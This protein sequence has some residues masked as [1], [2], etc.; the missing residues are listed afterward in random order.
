M[1]KGKLSVHTENILP[2]I[3]KWLYS[4][5]EIFLRE[6]VSNALD[7]INKVKKVALTEEIRDA[8]D[9]EYAIDIRIDRE[10][11]ELVIEDNGIGL[12]AEEIKKYIAQI[13]FS[14]A[15]EFVKQYEDSGDKNKAG[16]I[17]NFGLGFYSSFMVASRVEI[18]SLSYRPNAQAARW[19]SDGGEEYEIGEGTRTKRG[20][21]IKLILEDEDKNLLDKASINDLVRKYCDFMPVAIRVD[22]TQTNR[23]NPLWTKQPSALKKEDYVEFYRYLYPHQGDPLFY[24]HL[25]VDHP[26]HLQGIL[27][28]PRLAHEM[29]LNQSEVKI[30]CKQVFVTGEAQDLIPKFLTV[31]Q[32]VIDMPDLPLNVSRSYLQS[33]GQVRK[34]A[35]HIVKKVADRLIE[36]NKKSP[37]NYRD[38]WKDIAPFVKYGM[39]NDER[40]YEQAQ[41]ALLFQLADTNS[42]GP[43]DAA[44]EAVTDSAPAAQKSFTTIEDYVAAN[45]DKL[46]NKILYVSDLRTQ[47]GPLK[48]LQQQGIQVLL[49]DSMIDSHFMQFLEMKFPDY[50]FARADA[51]VSDHIVDKDAGAG[52]T[53][54]DGKDLDARVTEV[55]KKAIGDEK[56]TIQVET[57][58]DEALPALILLPEQMRRF[59]EMAAAMSGGR[60][61]PQFPAEHTLLLNRKN[62]IIAALGAPTLITGD[63]GESKQELTAKHVYNLARLAQGGVGPDDLEGFLRGSYN[64]LNKIL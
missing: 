13:A 5:K 12:T 56:V 39:L 1:E 29:E 46:D 6:L 19:S 31:L 18:D 47:A 24:I 21:S 40:F 35:A 50:K 22:G 38:I 4:E 25:N 59:S 43:V 41:S 30:Y 23:E 64:L 55:F 42:A 51:E 27:Y 9:D 60:E 45:K 57:L 36:E 58:K 26:F 62:P 44:S 37:E 16:I 7:A 34:I 3:K 61:A 17:G 14:G 20:T 48:L 52:L 32:G 8:D 53:D 63:S 2:I 10:Q 54:A 49:M 33:D 15:E 11:G 28:F